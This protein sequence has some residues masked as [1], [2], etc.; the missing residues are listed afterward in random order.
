M[1]YQLYEIS[2]RLV[3]IFLFSILKEV[4]KFETSSKYILPISLRNEIDND[5]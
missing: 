1:Q 5:L 2:I 4:K 3:D